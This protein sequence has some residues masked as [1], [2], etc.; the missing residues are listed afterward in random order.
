M[1]PAGPSRAAWRSVRASVS[2]RCGR[3]VRLLRGPRSRASA[4][5]RG[6]MGRRAPPRAL[7]SASADGLGDLPPSRRAARRASA[8]P[9]SAASSA[10]RSRRTRVQLARQAGRCAPLPRGWRAPRRRGGHCGRT[11]AACAAD[12]AASASNSVVLQPGEALARLGLGRSARPRHRPASALGLGVQA[13]PAPP[14][15]SSISVVLAAE[16]ARQLDAAALQLLGALAG[17]LL[18]GVEAVARQRSGAAARRRRPPPPRAGRAAHGRR[19]PASRAASACA[20][21]RS[22]TT[23]QV[24]LDLALG[25]QRRPSRASRQP[26]SSSSASAWRMSDASER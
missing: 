7:S 5:A 16:V 1:S 12:S 21:V 14:P 23:P 15:A 24:G 11:A 8:S 22:A 4:L 3:A 2:S 26:I 13:A 19:R 25:R 10:A 20:P 17:A 18:L 9:P 6:G